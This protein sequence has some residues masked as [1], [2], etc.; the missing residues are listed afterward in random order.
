MEPLFLGEIQM[1]AGNFAP[2]NWAFCDGSLLPIAQNTALFSILG[3]TYGGDGRT[4]FALPDLRSRIPM[5][6]GSGPGLSP[7]RLG[8]KGGNEDTT[9]SITNLP[10]TPVTISGDV[11]VGTSDEDGNT[12][13][14]GGNIIANSA[15]RDF[16]TG[17]PVESSL[18]GVTNSLSGQVPGSSTSFSNTPPFLCVNYIIALQGSYPTRD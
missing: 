8:Q 15:G 1:F 12:T 11:T 9:L 10:P 13:E 5:H 16:A 18:G 14:A 7:K 6:A 2:R 3:T 4:T 17:V